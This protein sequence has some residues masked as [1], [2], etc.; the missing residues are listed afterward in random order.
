MLDILVAGGGYVGLVAGRRAQ[1][2]RRRISPSRS[3]T[4]RP[5]T[6]GER[7]AAPPPSPPRPPMLEPLGVWDEIAAGSPADQR[8]DR[9]RF[10]HLRSGPAGVPDLRRRSRPGEPFAHMVDEPH[11]RTL[12]ARRQRAWR[13]PVIDRR[14]GRATSKHG[15]ASSDGRALERRHARGAAAG[16]LRRRALQAA[17]HRRHQD[18]GLG[19]R[20]VRHRHHRRA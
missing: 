19:L 15:E 20:P 17:R 3:S 10:A 18:R 13:Q 8:D 9:H 6:P 11:G 16:R 4:P 14:A 5:P 1:V 12:A 7:Y 2:R